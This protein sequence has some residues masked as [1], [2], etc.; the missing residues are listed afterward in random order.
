MY[1][2][3]DIY[4]NKTL[5]FQNIYRINKWF[6]NNNISKTMYNDSYIKKQMKNKKVVFKHYFITEKYNNINK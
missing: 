1:Y 5:E 2:V 6:Y 3:T 4:D